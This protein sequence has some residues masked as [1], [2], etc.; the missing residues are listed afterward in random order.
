M[1]NN[2]FKD[3]EFF[4]TLEDFISDIKEG[5]YSDYIDDNLIL[6]KT[7]AMPKNLIKKLVDTINGLNPLN[8]S[9]EKIRKDVFTN[10][11]F[12]TFIKGLLDTI[13]EGEENRKILNKSICFYSI[14]DYLL[15]QGFNGYFMRL[16]IQN[17]I[18]RLLKD[19]KYKG[20]Y[21]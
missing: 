7:V 9:G 10:N 1:D 3:N 18:I 17:S 21:Q 11:F 8:N 13:F 12:D 19:E 20:L 5:F 4:H 14:L 2:I 15:H 6:F 16:K